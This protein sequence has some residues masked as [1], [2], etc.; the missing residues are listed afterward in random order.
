MHVSVE[1]VS[2]CRECVQETQGPGLKKGH[3][4]AKSPSVRREIEGGPVTAG[5]AEEAGGAPESHTLPGLR[6]NDSRVLV[7]SMVTWEAAAR[8]G[9]LASTC[10]QSRA[11]CSVSLD[12]CHLLPVADVTIK[13]MAVNATPGAGHHSVSTWLVPFL[14]L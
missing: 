11:C 1:T 13:I 12:R 7:G 3:G 4:E 8:H 14:P 10:Q 2:S 6:A 9:I 5:L